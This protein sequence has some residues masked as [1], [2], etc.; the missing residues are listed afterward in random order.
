MLCLLLGLLSGSLLRSGC[1]RSGLRGLL[2]LLLR[3]YICLRLFI[4]LGSGS[5]I[6]LLRGGV[7]RGCRWLIGGSILRRGVVSEDGLGVYAGR[8][9][10]GRHEPCQCCCVF[11]HFRKTS[12]HRAYLMLIVILASYSCWKRAQNINFVQILSLRRGKVKRGEGWMR[13]RSFRISLGGHF[14]V[15]T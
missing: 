12:L 1:I 10:A 5:C 8:D 9:Y 2:S 3:G 13:G 7:L 15:R 14:R 4:C 11:F 6:F